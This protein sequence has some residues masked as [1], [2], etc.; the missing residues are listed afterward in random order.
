MGEHVKRT[1]AFACLLTATALASA[2][3]A[4]PAV[5]AG[6]QYQRQDLPV[7]V[8]DGDVLTE[9]SSTDQSRIVGLAS[10]QGYGRGVLWVNGALEQMPLPAPDWDHVVPRAV[11]NTGVVAGYQ[12]NDRGVE[13]RHQ[14]FRYENGAYEALQTEPAKQSKAVAV[15]EAGDVLGVVWQGTS[16]SDG[17]V[18][19]WPRNGVRKSIARGTPIGITAQRQVVVAGRWDTQVINADTGASRTLPGQATWVKLDND[20]VL[21]G[22]I[23]ASWNS[24]ITEWTLRGVKVATYQGGVTPLGRNS[25]GTLLGTYGRPNGADVPSVWDS[26]GRTEVVADRVPLSTAYADVTD[27][28]TLIGTYSGADSLARPALWVCG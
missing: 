26:T 7:P 19:L 28:G 18:V 23:D 11:D 10:H 4:P 21:R 2:V 5:A 9:G 22:E 12:R 17:D 24:Q 13:L 14:A 16:D 27:A 6:C 25:G 1:R 20:R 3:A 8:V 15:N